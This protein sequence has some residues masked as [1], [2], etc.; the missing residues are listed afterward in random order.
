MLLERTESGWPLLIFGSLSIGVLDVS[1][2]MNTIVEPLS[3]VTSGLLGLPAITIIPLLYGLIRKEGALVILVA[4]AGT[5]QLGE[6]M[7]PIQFFVFALVV[8]IYVPCVA[9]FSVLGK[10]LGWKSAVLITLS[11]IGI[12]LLV[13]GV[14]FHLNPLG[15]AG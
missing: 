10:E 5:A 9:T 3:P 14:F 4:V 7:T 13:G 11:T 12:A 1:G 6:F 2:V 15:L 8:A